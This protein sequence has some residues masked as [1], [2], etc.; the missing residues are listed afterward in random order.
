MPLTQ[1]HVEVGRFV[2]GLTVPSL[3][4]GEA[5]AWPNRSSLSAF[6]PC[7]LSEIKLLSGKQGQN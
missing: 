7:L 1:K 4:A 2:S 6:P 5:F 3:L